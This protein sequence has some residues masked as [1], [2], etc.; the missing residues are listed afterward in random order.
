MENDMKMCPFCGGKVYPCYSSRTE[1][2]YVLHYKTRHLCSIQEIV[3]RDDVGIKS[4]A[5]VREE[6]N[7]RVNDG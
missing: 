3:M 5:D 4:L 7:R 6:W 2:Y 1:R